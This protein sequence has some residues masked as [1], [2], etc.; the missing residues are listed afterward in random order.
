MAAIDNQKEPILI[1]FDSY[2]VSFALPPAP[3][4]RFDGIESQRFSA[5]PKLLSIG[6]LLDLKFRTN[7]FFNMYFIHGTT[8]HLGFI[9]T[10][11]PSLFTFLQH[12]DAWPWQRQRPSRLSIAPCCPYRRLSIKLLAVTLV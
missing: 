10:F 11:K 6:L 1:I 3:L 2:D 7:I 5:P 9:N 12:A 4:Q 8:G